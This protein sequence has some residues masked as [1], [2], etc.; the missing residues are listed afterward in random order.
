VGEELLCSSCGARK[1]VK[2]A[3]GGPGTTAAA[4]PRK[5][6][7]FGDDDLPKPVKL[8]DED[9]GRRTCRHCVH[10][11]VNPFTQRCALHDKNI[12]ATDTCLDFEARDA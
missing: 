5:L 10:Y 3:A 6:S 7:I 4:A 11:L 12:E 8:F 9:E 2:P 1:P